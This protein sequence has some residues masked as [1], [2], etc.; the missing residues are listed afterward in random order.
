MKKVLLQKG[1]LRS[2]QR[3]EFHQRRHKH[4]QFHFLSSADAER[5]TEQLISGGTR[6]GRSGTG[7][8]YG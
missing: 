4:L 1:F 5:L 8:F 7:E 3:A 6:R 2:A